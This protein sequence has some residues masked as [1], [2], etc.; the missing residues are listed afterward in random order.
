MN[1]W[2][3]YNKKNEEAKEEKP[4]NIF[5]N[6]KTKIKHPTSLAMQHEDINKKIL[7]GKET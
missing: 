7:V 4:V 5:W 2:R 1:R 6:K 3:N